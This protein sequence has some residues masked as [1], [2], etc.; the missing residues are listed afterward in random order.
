M[1]EV[2]VRSQRVVRIGLVLMLAA[3]VLSVLVII[4]KFTP[5]ENSFYPGCIFHSAT[6]LHCIGCGLTRSLHSTL[7]GDWE[8][9]IAWHALAFIIL[10]LIGFSFFSSLLSWA[11]DWRSSYSS[12]R[13]KTW[14]LRLLLLFL[15]AFTIL[16]NIPVYPFSLLAPHELP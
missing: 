9:A 7:N 13:L 12:D 16:R 15:I 8:Q 1:W 3:L 14:A 4:R 11:M 6:G 5:T 10:P 2:Q